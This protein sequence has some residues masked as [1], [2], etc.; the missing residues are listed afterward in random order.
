MDGW[1]DEWMDGC[2]GEWMDGWIKH[3]AFPGQT[4]ID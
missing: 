4:A 2:M 3:Y 1:M